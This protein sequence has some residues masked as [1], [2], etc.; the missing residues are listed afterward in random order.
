MADKQI[1]DLT[2][3]SAM[4]DGS[5]FVIEQGGAAKSANWG[6]VK[7]Y[8]S[9]GVAP[10]YS[11]SDTYNVGDYVIY[12][13]HLYRCTTAITTP[14]NWTAVHWATA[15]LGDDVFDLDKRL[16]DVTIPFINLFNQYDAIKGYYC[17]K[18]SGNLVAG[19]AFYV[20]DFIAVNA[21]QEYKVA[22]GLGSAS[23]YPT[24]LFYDANKTLL[25]VSF[26]PS[27][28]GYNVTTP[29]DCAFIRVNGA[30]ARINLQMI[31]ALLD[32]S[33]LPYEVIVNGYQQ[34]GFNLI[35]D[36][37]I[38]YDRSTGL[39]SS[40]TN[41]SIT[42]P[43]SGRLHSIGTSVNVGS[44]KYLLYDIS[45][46]NIYAS[47]T[48]GVSNTVVLLA[49]LEARRFDG[50][51]VDVFIADSFPIFTFNAKANTLSINVTN[52]P[53]YILHNGR[54]YSLPTGFSQV[55]TLPNLC[56]VYYDPVASQFYVGTDFN[57]DHIKGVLIMTRH[58]RRLNVINGLTVN[59]VLDNLAGKKVI[60]YGDSLTWY[61]GKA[62]TWGP[63]QGETCIG[64]ES[65]LINELNVAQASNYGASGTTTPQ[66][67]TNIVNQK[68]NLVNYDYMT[69]MGGDNDDRLNVSVGT[70]Q[71]VGGT[72]DT[73]TVCGALQNAIEQALAVNPNLRII[74]MTE[75]M[76]WTYQNGSL[77]RVSDLIPDAYRKVAKQYG[78]PLIDNWAN[79]GVNE[80]TR[81]TLLAD[82]PDTENQLYMYH[83]N[84]DGWIR[85]SKYIV[86]SFRMI[87]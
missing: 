38:F 18:V 78:L 47:D 4:T 50:Q 6:M 45:N 87:G 17:E 10:Q 2:S 67:C 62:F 13:G 7:N 43:N 36:N 42:F 40:K 53:A 64:F 29:S 25:S 20:S 27:T 66:I 57:R 5:L 16:H 21:G 26:N 24:V 72:F 15:V 14:E 37:S 39:L 33:Y 31:T 84:N 46:F 58:Y 68:A 41:M 74:L 11:S 70:V 22:V 19:S 30:L 32:A 73:L 69:I 59:T 85:I 44:G 49:F 77:D 55:L 65:Y 71:P 81:N 82:P 80:L 3:A 34:T 63:H 56:D 28:S 76:G 48:Y 60:C 35:S 9:P 61:D 51:A 23:D 52:T 1:S 75:P 83:P 8:I 12:N 86:N 79:S 54:Y